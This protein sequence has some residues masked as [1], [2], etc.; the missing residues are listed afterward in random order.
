MNATPAPRRVRDEAPLEPDLAIVDAH[1]HLWNDF[2]HIVSSHGYATDYM[3]PDMVADAAG[4]N[5]IATVY[6]NALMRYRTTGPEE[7][8]PVGETEFAAEVAISAANSPMKAC[9]GIVSSADFRLG[10]RVGAVLDAHAEA[11]KGRFRGI[12]TAFARTEEPGLISVGPH[13]MEKDP[14]LRQGAAELA[15]RGLVMDVFTYHTQLREFADLVDS[16]PDLQ[17]VLNHVG[18]YIAVG[19]YAKNP[20]E[21]FAEWKTGMT[22]VARRPNVALKMG[23]FGMKNLSKDLIDRGGAEHSDDLVQAWRPIFETCVEVFGAER[24]MLESNFPPDKLAGAYNQFWNAFKRMSKSYTPDE[25]Q[26]LFSG[27]ATRI[28]N[29]DLG[30]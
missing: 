26:A 23:G 5:V 8:R 1:H 7:L 27:T 12:R 21:T 10:S 29:L 28:Y 24:C 16:L 19:R 25:R 2:G 6:A 15:R 22:E 17:F 4:H 20:S 9:A 3:L 30:S 13:G 18:G 11:G 14:A